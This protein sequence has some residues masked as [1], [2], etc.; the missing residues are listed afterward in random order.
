MKKLAAIAILALGVGVVYAQEEQSELKVSINPASKQHSLYY[1]GESEQSV[2]IKIYNPAGKLI[3]SEKFAA[4]GFK[5]T[6]S[7]TTMSK[8]I[9]TAK[10]TAGNKTMTQSINHGVALR[11]LAVD[12]EEM[13]SSKY[14]LAVRGIT[15]DPVAVKVEDSAGKVVY[16]KVI[17][18]DTDFD[19]VFDLSKVRSKNVT[20]TV[21]SNN[22]SVTKSI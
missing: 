1:L 16:E 21:Q 6:Y 11:D 5:K 18:T 19:Q 9:Y 10:V 12:V 20:F 2:K 13:G 22:K 15:G 17:Y 14:K 4:V 3:H 8:G 7:F